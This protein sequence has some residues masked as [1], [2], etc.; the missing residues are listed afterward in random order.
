MPELHVVFQQYSH[1]SYSLTLSN[2]PA[3]L[4]KDQNCSG[5][6]CSADYLMWPW[7]FCKVNY[8]WI[9]GYS[10]KC[11]IKLLLQD[12]WL[13]FGSEN[14]SNRNDKELILVA[15]LLP[16]HFYHP[17]SLW[18]CLKRLPQLFCFCLRCWYV[19]GVAGTKNRTPCRLQMEHLA[20]REWFCLKYF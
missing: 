10:L 16:H 19:T 1:K 9:T 6:S 5:G 20:E 15:K 3:Y 12:V 7:S 11:D 14:V 18:C 4:S 2:S 13:T 8:I 17:T